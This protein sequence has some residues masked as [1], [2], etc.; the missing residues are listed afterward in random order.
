MAFCDFGSAFEVFD[1]N[2]EE[3]PEV[4]VGKITNEKPCKITCLNDEKHQLED[5]DTVSLR[6][7][8]GTSE[9]NGKEFQVKG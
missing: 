3:L 8:Q 2:G 4:L 6:E 7:I 1:K 5:G 9:L